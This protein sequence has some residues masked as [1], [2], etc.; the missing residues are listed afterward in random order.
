[1]TQS[2]HWLG[3]VFS[4][5]KDGIVNFVSSQILR[6]NNKTYHIPNYYLLFSPKFLKAL[7]NLH[8]SIIIVVKYLTNITLV[9]LYCTMTVW[10][11]QYK[12]LLDF[13]LYNINSQTHNFMYLNHL[14]I[15]LILFSDCNSYIN[16][17]GMFLRHAINNNIL[18]PKKNLIDYCFTKMSND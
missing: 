11:N 10:N 12:N 6:I 7:Q 2:N 14:E 15:F 3:W 5:N 4:I 9:H 1:M 18:V 16:K 17:L 8:L 13:I